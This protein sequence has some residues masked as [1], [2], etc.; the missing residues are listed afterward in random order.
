MFR[1]NQ[2]GVASVEF[3]VVLPLLMLLI[4]GTIE[5]GV[6]FY[7]KQVVVNA[8]REA[9]RAGIAG[10]DNATMQ[11][12]AS[13]YCG[14]RLIGLKNSIS[15]NSVIVVVTPPDAHND[16]TVSVS[17]DYQLLFGA[18]VGIDQAEV[19]GRTVMR[20]EPL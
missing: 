15:S 14:N 19:A 12:I 9:V 5:F 8:S 18:L 3:A 6:L 1:L 2:K 20:M 16:L 11:Q 13:S 10:A 4:C 7:D 17:L